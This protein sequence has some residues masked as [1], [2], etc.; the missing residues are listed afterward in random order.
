MG[1]RG[2]GGI[3]RSSRREVKSERR[4]GLP[5]YTRAKRSDTVGRARGMARRA[6]GGGVW[7]GG[8]RASRSVEGWASRLQ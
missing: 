1:R 3:R 8:R 4:P 6:R 7:G 2:E 5:H